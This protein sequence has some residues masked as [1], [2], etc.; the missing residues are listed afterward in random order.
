MTM[1]D[2]NKEKLLKLVSK[3]PSNALEA[4][5]GRIQNRDKIKGYQSIAIKVL[6][7]LDEL[8]IS[9][10]DLAILLKVKPS[11]VSRIVSGKYSTDPLMLNELQTVL[12]VKLL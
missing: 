8:E 3:Q 1:K 2:S 12:K 10:R 4:M 5:R 9:P 11:K 7:R 6:S